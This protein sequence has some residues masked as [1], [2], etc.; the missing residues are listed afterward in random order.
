MAVLDLTLFSHECGGAMQVS[1]VLPVWD[2]R[3]GEVDPGTA[4]KTV[5]LLHGGGGDHRSYLANT[6]IER[7]ALERRVAVVTPFVG[8]CHYAD[9][10]AFGNFF[11]YLSTELPALLRKYLPLSARREDNFVCGVSAG[12]LG[13]AKLAFNHPDRYAACG[14]FSIGPM[15]P[16]MMCASFKDKP[17]PLQE[18]LAAIYGG[19]PSNA[20]KTCDDIWWVMENLAH[21]HAAATPEAS[22]EIPA[23][24]ACCGEDDFSFPGYRAFKEKVLELGLD[25]HF[26]EGP[27]THAWDYWNRAIPRFLTWLDDRRLL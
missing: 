25:A 16:A 19:D 18:R 10:P 9:I 13:A 22:G 12:G 15:S 14:V 7:W 5:W 2:K 3:D 20:D 6:P 4:F 24:F 11:T 21:K 23:L 1:V 17:G 26:E 8:R 27:G